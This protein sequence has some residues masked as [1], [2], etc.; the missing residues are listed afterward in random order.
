MCPGS[1]LSPPRPPIACCDTREGT[2]T[3]PRYTGM[4]KDPSSSGT[5]GKGSQ[6]SPGGWRRTTAQPRGMEKDHSSAQGDRGGSQHIPR[7]CGRIPAHP[8]RVGKN[9]SSVHRAGKTFV[10]SHR[11]SVSVQAGAGCRALAALDPSHGAP[12]S[13]LGGVGLRWVPGG[14]AHLPGAAVCMY[15]KSCLWWDCGTGLQSGS[16]RH[17]PPRSQQKPAPNSSPKYAKPQQVSGMSPVHTDR[18]CP[19]SPCSDAWWGQGAGQRATL[20]CWT[21]SR[22]RVKGMGRKGPGLGSAEAVS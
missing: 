4:G 10:P 18:V 15:T 12:N 16:G 5:D 6:L 20:G 13:V 14:L 7:A 9:P 2:A 8:S 11:G 17:L 3:P 22:G 21:A 19:L 1:A